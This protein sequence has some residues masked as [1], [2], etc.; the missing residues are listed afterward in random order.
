MSASPVRSDR[1][2]GGDGEQAEDNAVRYNNSVPEADLTPD[3][4]GRVINGGPDDD[5]ARLGNDTLG[6]EAEFP[7]E[8]ERRHSRSPEPPQ[9]HHDDDMRDVRDDDR[10]DRDERD[11][12]REK[13][14]DD[15]RRRRSPRSRS[16]ERTRYRKRERD[17]RS[18]SFEDRYRN[19]GRRD[20]SR[21]RY[22][23]ERSRDRYE[24]RGGRRERSWS[25]GRG[26]GGIPNR[27]PPPRQLHLYVA[28]LQFDISDKDLDRKFQRYGR[29]REA[30]I[31][32]NQRNGESKGFGF[33]V[34][35]T[36]DEVR[37]AIKSLDGS[38]WRGRRLIVERARTIK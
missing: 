32:R 27:T 3:E 8:P 36:E 2:D 26:G 34:M 21:E 29:V 25:P 17:E 18:R 38:T 5:E 16:R 7:E 24:Y 30:R 33:V 1:Y 37:D 13:D 35:D 10:D 22:R 14:I 9:K 28:G 23:R 12:S 6:V 19:G 11:R 31:V 15:D 4:G 20:R